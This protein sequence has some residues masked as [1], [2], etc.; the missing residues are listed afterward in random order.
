MTAA[1]R[2]AEVSSTAGR[3]L[4]PTVRIGRVSVGSCHPIVVQSMT[5]TD[6]ADA[7]AT[8]QQVAELA[9]AGS[10]LVRITVNTLEA[11]RAI[12]E[13]KRRLDMMSCEVPLIGDFHYNGHVLLTRH[14]DCARALGISADWLLGLSDRPEP[15]AD[16]LAASLS[17]TEAP[18]ALFDA[19]IYG[20]HQEA[21]GYKIRP[22]VC[23]SAGRG[24]SGCDNS[25]SRWACFS[26]WARRR[27]RIRWIRVRGG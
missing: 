22:L 27:S 12:P 5:N 1:G 15:I 9:R 23:G 17:L 6:T 2:G 25:R 19:A 24:P 20:W 11:A 8:A 10:E 16:L 26:S 7:K 21:A 3:R 13:I 18:R 14:P 4:T